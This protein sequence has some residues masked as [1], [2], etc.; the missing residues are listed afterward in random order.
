M[1]DQKLSEEFFGS[2]SK[3]IILHKADYYFRPIFVCVLHCFHNKVNSYHFF[4]SKG[5]TQLQHLWFDVYHVN[6]G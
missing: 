5:G 4:W 3:I 1:C 6:D 2:P